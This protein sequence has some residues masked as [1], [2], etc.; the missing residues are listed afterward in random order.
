M[1]EFEGLARGA[2]KPVDRLIGIAHREQIPF[3]TGK[4]GEDLDLGEVGILK[5]I[6]QDE[7]SPAPRLGQDGVVICVQ[8]SV[9]PA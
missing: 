9:R 4:T 3:V 6:G 2:P 1:K 8:H 5:F 7:A